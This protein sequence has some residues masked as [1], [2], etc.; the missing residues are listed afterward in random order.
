MRRS[1]VSIPVSVALLGIAWLA[2]CAGSGRDA[3]AP[4][5]ANTAQR[6][7]IRASTLAIDDAR[8]RDAG[9]DV[10]DWLTHGRTYAEQRHSPLAQI[11]D[12]NVRSVS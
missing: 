10:G 1:F 7:R 2:A 12:G 6:D 4:G 11:H 3:S 5:D 9:A 8:L